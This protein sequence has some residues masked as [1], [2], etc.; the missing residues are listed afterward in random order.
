MPYFIIIET[1][2]GFEVACVPE[3][4]TASQIARDRGAILIDAGPYRTF[5][6]AHEVLMTMPNPYQQQ[7]VY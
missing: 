6:A 4:K 7:N 1:T 3:G 5:Q 2:D